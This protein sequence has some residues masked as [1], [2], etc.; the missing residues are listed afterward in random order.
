HEFLSGT[1]TF[2]N[3]S[4][5]ITRS[6]KLLYTIARNQKKAVEQSLGGVNMM[7]LYL[8]CW[9][10]LGILKKALAP[11]G[12]PDFTA[13]VAFEVWRMIR[14]AIRSTIVLEPHDVF[15][16]LMISRLSCTGAESCPMDA[17]SKASEEFGSDEPQRLCESKL[18]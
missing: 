15:N 8:R 10:S 9:D 13:A 6:G 11:Q 2:H 14:V 18:K 3:P 4:W 7:P 1:A 16:E 17:V 5:I 12:R